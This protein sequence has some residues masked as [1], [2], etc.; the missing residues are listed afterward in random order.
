M[1]WRRSCEVVETTTGRSFA[2]GDFRRR[3]GDDEVPTS[4]EMR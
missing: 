2:I 1:W 4:G 3:G